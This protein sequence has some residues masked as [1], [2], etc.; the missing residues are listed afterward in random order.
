MPTRDVVDGVVQS[1]QIN[2]TGNSVGNTDI[3]Q[4]AAGIG[5]L[6]EPHPRLGVGQFFWLAFQGAGVRPLG[7]RRETPVGEPAAKQ[8]QS[9]VVEPGVRAGGVS[10]AKYPLSVRVSTRVRRR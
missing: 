7:R 8:L 9:G 4:R 5:H 6:D 1:G 2:L 3:Q 10:H